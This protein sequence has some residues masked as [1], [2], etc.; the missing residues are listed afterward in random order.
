MEY[1]INVPDGLS[2][3]RAMQVIKQFEEQLRA[4]ADLERQKRLKSRKEL[5]Q[6]LR[7]HPVAFDGE[8]PSREEKNQR[9]VSN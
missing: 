6:W 5:A 7:N 9:I 2:K 1:T 4:E 8:I 3:E